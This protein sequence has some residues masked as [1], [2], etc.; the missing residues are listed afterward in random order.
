MRN[1][2]ERTEKNAKCQ[3]KHFKNE[4]DERLTQ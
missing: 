1:K 4:D 3:G 2:V